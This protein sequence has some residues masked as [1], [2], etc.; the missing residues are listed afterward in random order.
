MGELTQGALCWWKGK[1]TPRKPT[2]VLGTFAIGLQRGSQLPER[3]PRNCQSS[4]WALSPPTRFSFVYMW[5][6]VSCCY[7]PA[8]SG[9]NGFEPGDGHRHRPRTDRPCL[10]RPAS[11]T[12]TWAG[13]KHCYSRVQAEAEHKA[14]MGR[15][16]V[17][18]APHP[19][20]SSRLG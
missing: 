3:V 16:S 6:L 11:A 10:V 17:L 1:H 14:T 12:L 8:T 2:W 5:T 15:P 20:P 13:S 9:I 4:C 19:W 7:P 18:W